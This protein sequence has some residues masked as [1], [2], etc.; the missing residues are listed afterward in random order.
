MFPTQHT[1]ERDLL[2]GLGLE[3][4]IKI[5]WCFVNTDYLSVVWNLGND[6][7]EQVVK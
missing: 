4:L 2:A 1:D 3:I 5:F 6:P 7:Q